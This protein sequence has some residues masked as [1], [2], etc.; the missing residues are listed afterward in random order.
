MTDGSGRAYLDN[1]EWYINKIKNVKLEELYETEDGYVEG[2]LHGEHATIHDY[3]AICTVE[4]ADNSSYDE[5]CRRLDGYNLAYS[6][7]LNF[8]YDPVCSRGLGA[9]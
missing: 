7:K 4:E 3:P 6:S 8:K 5:K 9:G 1:E 2:Y